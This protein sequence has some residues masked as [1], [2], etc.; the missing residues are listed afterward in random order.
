MKTFIVAS[1]VIVLAAT[2]G[3]A[4]KKKIKVVR[5]APALIAEVLP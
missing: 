5:P 2:A 1:I 4:V 3:A